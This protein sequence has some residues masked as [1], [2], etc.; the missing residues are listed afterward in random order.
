MADVLSILADGHVDL[1]ETQALRK[2]YYADGLVE[3]AELREVFAIKDGSESYVPEFAELV[4]DMIADF[5][6]EDEETPGVVDAHEAAVLVELI[7]ADGVFDDAE[8]LGIQIIAD[9]ADE[10]DDALL[11]LIDQL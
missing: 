5:A 4:A 6:L 3:E 8:R 10:I 11:E 7:G 9:T 2:E 1:E